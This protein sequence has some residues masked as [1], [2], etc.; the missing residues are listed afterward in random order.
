[1]DRITGST[2]SEVYRGFEEIVNDR[3]LSYPS[4]P[5][6]Q[7][8]DLVIDTLHFSRIEDNTKFYN[9]EIEGGEVQVAVEVS[10]VE[11]ILS[12]DD[13]TISAIDSLDDGGRLGNYLEKY[14]AVNNIS[15]AVE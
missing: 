6:L 2:P 3:D 15:E 5:L 8:E 11:E 10:E 7:E 12:E 4:S 13:Y 14:F 9:L 1:M